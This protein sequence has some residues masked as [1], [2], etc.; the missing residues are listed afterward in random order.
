MDKRLKFY[1]AAGEVTGSNYLLE[2]EG[3]RVLI[4]CGMHQGRNNDEKNGEYFPYDPRSIDAV[5][6]TH[7]HID[8]SGRIPLLVKRGFSGKI[9]ATSPTVEL[10]ALLWR[11][12]A[13]LMAEEAEWNNRKNARRGLDPVEPLYTERDAEKALEMMHHIPYDETVAVLEPFKIRC[14]NAGHILGSAI[15]EVWVGADAQ[16]AIKIVF[17][18]DIGPMQSA[19]EKTPSLIEDA[20][21]VV[22][23]S[24]YGDRLHK[25]LQETRTE[26]QNAMIQAVA[27]DSKILVPTFVVDRAQRMLY[28]FQLLQKERPDVKFPAIYFDSP[29][30][31]K[32]TEIYRKNLSLLSRELQEYLMAGLD[33][34]EPKG[35]KYVKSVEESKTVNEMATGVVMAGSGMCTG[36]RIVHHL[37]HSLWKANSHVFF[38]GYQAKGTLGRRLVEGEKELRIAGEDV[39]VRAHLHTLNGFS[40]H[41]DRRDLLQWASNFPQSTKFF[42]TH[43]E[44]HSSQA[45][46]LGLK[47]LGFSALVPSA[48]SNY[49]LTTLEGSTDE[50]ELQRPSA[51]SNAQLQLLI[52]DISAMLSE[53]GKDKVSL[54]HP[55]DILP[56]LESSKMLLK[57]ATK[58]KK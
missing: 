22:I 34:F 50:Q 14:R 37:K 31:T 42:V 45:L 11:D 19:I 27:D 51:T 15:V 24:T 32:T 23:E 28:E 36:G 53:I 10:C 12:S 58:K 43:G 13:K 39:T 57:A 4:D 8:H 18:G 46:A 25:T 35:L 44:P 9:W 16:S 54:S 26:F 38:V 55:E 3:K 33:P 29:M 30:G 17:S 47:D 6:L 41:A 40:A 5:I 56:Y 21:F 2:T 1:G 7:A 49:D 20:D 52:A 48:G